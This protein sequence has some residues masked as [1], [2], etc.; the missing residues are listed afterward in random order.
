MVVVEAAAS[1]AVVDHA[2]SH[3][4]VAAAGVGAGVGADVA[5]SFGRHLSGSQPK[6][7]PQADTSCH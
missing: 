4:V 1:G 7:L 2:S 3:Y 6:T 5:V